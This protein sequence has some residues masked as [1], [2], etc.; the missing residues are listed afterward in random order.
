MVEYDSVIPILGIS[1]Y[2]DCHLLAVPAT[3]GTAIVVTSE[4]TYY[5]GRIFVAGVFVTA[6]FT[7]LRRVDF[8]RD[9]VQDILM[10]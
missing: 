3:V 5:V 10:K 2:Q 6:L 7:E 4:L 9:C 8:I 1:S